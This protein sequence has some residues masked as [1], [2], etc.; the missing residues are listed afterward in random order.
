MGVDVRHRKRRAERDEG[1]RPVADRVPHH[2][3]ELP[4][5]GTL[6][7]LHPL[8]RE[9]VIF[10]HQIVGDGRRNDHEVVAARR[11]RGVNETGLHRLELAAVAPSSFRVEE[12]IVLLQHL[13]DVGLEG[14]EIRRIL[15]IA[16]NRNGAGDVAVNQS[17]RPAEQIDAGRDQRRTDAVVVEHQR[18]DQV[19]GMALVVRRVDDAV[20]AD[21]AEHVVQILVLALDL[22][23]NGIERMLQRSIDR[24][25][26]GRAQFVEVAVDALARRL[27]PA[28][29]V[30]PAEVLDHLFAGQH[31][32]CDVIKHGWPRTIALSTGPGDSSAG[33]QRLP[34]DRAAHRVGEFTRGGRPAEIASQRFA[35]L[36]DPR[37]GRP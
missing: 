27:V 15:G 18:L 6:L 8:P 16:S 28:R 36:Q 10:E 9:D 7:L 21:G 12:E 1:A 20:I 2:L 3:G 24:V 11:Q 35:R 32:L 34:F 23:E 33:S 22:P 13:G 4:R 25:P 17:E 14:D 5:E 31:S 37:R 29:A 26:L 30:C 19:V